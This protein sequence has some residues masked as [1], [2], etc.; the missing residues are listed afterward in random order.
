MSAFTPIISPM[1]KTLYTLDGGPDPR[2]WLRLPVKRKRKAV[3]TALMHM[4]GVGGSVL[5]LILSVEDRLLLGK[6]P[7]MKA[8]L[9]SHPNPGLTCQTIP[10]TAT[11][12]SGRTKA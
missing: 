6:L 12:T 3:S 1:K 9:T 4:P 11:M 10:S 2:L 5:D 8:M 7:K